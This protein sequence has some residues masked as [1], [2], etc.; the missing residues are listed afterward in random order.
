MRGDR[1]H[2]SVVVPAYNESQ[3]I[4]PV[5]DRLFDAVHLPCEVLVVVDDERG[6]TVLVVADYARQAPRIRCVGNTYG[7]GPANAIRFG[8]DM[9]AAP[10]A[11]VTMADGCDDPRQIDELTR[12]RGRRAC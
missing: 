11:V 9:A 3:G 1:S 5:L 6:T 2:A 12:S 7:H 10:V 4:I 8:I